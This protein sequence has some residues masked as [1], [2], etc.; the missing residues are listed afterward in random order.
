[1]TTRRVQDYAVGEA[2]EERLKLHSPHGHEHVYGSSWW[3][4]YVHIIVVDDRRESYVHNARKLYVQNITKKSVRSRAF[5][6]D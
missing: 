3:L 1:M 5:I 6:T 2:R 4:F